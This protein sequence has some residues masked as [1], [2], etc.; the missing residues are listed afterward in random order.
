MDPVN[1]DACRRQMI[2]LANLGDRAS[3][4]RAY[5]AL[6]R[7]LR[8]DLGVQPARDTVALR[9]KLAVSGL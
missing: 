4:L 8:D 5:D 3:A 1:E 7:A 2:C 6:V 9:E